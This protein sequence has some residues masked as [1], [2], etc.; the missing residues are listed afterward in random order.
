MKLIY[1]RQN[2]NMCGHACVAMLANTTPDRVAQV[3]GHKHPTA[4][5]ELYTLLFHFGVVCEFELVPCFSEREFPPVAIVVLPSLCAT[6]KHVVVKYGDEI[7]DPACGVYMAASL[8]YSIKPT[9]VLKYAR[10][11]NVR[12]PA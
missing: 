7:Y 4:W 1:Q 10:V 3:L 12:S 9:E 8:E 11:L 2:S 5:R 6:L